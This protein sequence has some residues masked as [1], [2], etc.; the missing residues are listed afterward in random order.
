MDLDHIPSLGVHSL[1]GGRE[2]GASGQ[3]GRGRASSCA[4]SWPGMGGKGEWEDSEKRDADRRECGE[5]SRGPLQCHRAE[6]VNTCTNKQLSC[7]TVASC[8]SVSHSSASTS[9]TGVQ[10][11]SPT[12]RLNTQ[13]DVCLHLPP[14]YLPPCVH[15]LVCPLDRGDAQPGHGRR[16]IQAGGHGEGGNELALREAG[17]GE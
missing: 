7:V 4:S 9:T 10:P 17:K 14:P 15:Q 12:P 6:S 1:S 2:C 11:T 8:L 16:T 13:K 3:G 5:V